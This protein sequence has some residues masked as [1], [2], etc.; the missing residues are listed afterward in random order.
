MSSDSGLLV[1]RRNTGIGLASHDQDGTTR[2]AKNKGNRRLEH[3]LGQLEKLRA[4]RWVPVYLDW[5]AI[6]WP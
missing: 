4:E 5:S 1:G 6:G 2:L 3:H